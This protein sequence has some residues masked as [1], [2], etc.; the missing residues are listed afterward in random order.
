MIEAIYMISDCTSEMI[1][2]SRQFDCANSIAAVYTKHYTIKQNLHMIPV[3]FTI[4]I[5]EVKMNLQE[6]L[7]DSN[8]YIVLTR[9][10]CQ[11]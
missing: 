3:W 7:V 11:K 10:I 2:Q 1:M 8:N 9:S 4:Q 6:H 5:Y